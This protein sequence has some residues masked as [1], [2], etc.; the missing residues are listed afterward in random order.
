MPRSVHAH[1]RPCQ[2]LRQ[3]L[4]P[5]FEQIRSY[6]QFRD[7]LADAESVEH[8]HPGIGLMTLSRRA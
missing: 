6:P 2:L 8:R 5:A 1:E 3:R 7:D 4:P